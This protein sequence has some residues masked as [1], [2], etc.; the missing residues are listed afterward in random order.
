MSR[1]PVGAQRDPE[2]HAEGLEIGA[3][4]VKWVRRRIGGSLV[5]EVARHEGRP[6]DKIREM[7]SRHEDVEPSRVFVTGQAAKLLLDCPYLPE[8][9]CLETALAY[10]GLDPDILLSLGGETFSVYAVKEGRIH[11]VI[12]S[13]KCAAGTGEFIV[14]QLQRM[15][16]SL[17]DGIADARRSRLVQL[18]T[19]CS[20]HCKSDA[21]HK[22]NKGECRPGDVARS[23]IH[24]LAGKVSEL[25][26]LAQWPTRTIVLC[27][28]VS[29]NGLFVEDFC[30]HFADA[31]VRVVPESPYFEAFGACLAASGLPDAAIRAPRRRWFRAS[32]AS[33]ST[34]GSLKKAESL[35]DYRVQ[36]RAE[37]AIREGGSYLLGVDA[38]STTTKAILLDAADGRIGASAY[39]RTLGNPVRAVKA[40]LAQ[41]IRQVGNERIDIVQAGVTGSGRELVAV[42]LDDC[43]SFNEILAHAR[44]AI[45]EVPDVDTVFEIGGQDSKY[46]SFLE[47]VAVDYAMNEGCSA[48]T[49]SF[50][51]ESA[52]VDMGVGMEDISRIAEESRN[53]IRFGE[54]CAAF[55]NTDVRDALQQGA[56]R[57][58]VIGGLVYSIADN[59]IS[60]VVGPRQ[61]GENLLFLGGLALN[62]AVA[63]AMAARTQR[64][65]V[66]PPHPELMGCVGAALMVRDRLLTGELTEEHIELDALVEG[67]MESKETFRC[68]SCENLCEIQRIAVRGKVRPFGGLCSKYESL[69]HECG[70][71]VEGQD[72]V[73]VRNRMMFDEFGHQPA[74]DA[75]GTIGLPMA[76]TAFELFPFYAKLIEGLGYRVIL[77][78]RPELGDLK[79][80][81]AVCYPCKLMHA[82]VC[83]LLDRNVDFVLVPHVIEMAIPSGALHSYACPSTTVIPDILRAAFPNTDNRI[84]SP[85]VGLS[86]D[87]R[88]TTLKE[89]AKLGPRLGL[90]TEAARSAGERALSHYDRFCERRQEAAE[91]MFQNLKHEPTVILAGRPYTT[92]APVVNLS[93]PRKIMSRGYHVVPSDMLPRLDGACPP[94]DVWHF[95]QQITNA[96]AHIGANPN[97][98]LCMVSCFSCG[99]DSSIA[100]FLRQQ[101]AG[102]TFCYLEI[103]SHTAH[104]G[105]ET[106]LGAF[107]DIIEERRRRKPTAIKT[108]PAREGDQE[109]A[110]RTGVRQARLSENLD[111][112]LDSDG[113]RVEYDDPRV[114]DAWTTVHSPFALRMIT[115]MYERKGRRIRTVGR[116]RPQTMQA[117][118]RLCSGREC[119]PMTAMVGATLEDVSL[120]RGHDEITIYLGLDQEGPCQNG[121]WPLVWD[122]FGRRLQLRNVI[123]GVRPKAENHYL[124]LGNDYNLAISR[125]LILGD[126][127]EEAKNTVA[128]LAEDKAAALATFNAAFERFAQRFGDEGENAVEPALQEWAESVARIPLTATP[129]T[130]P[131]VLIIGGLNLLFVHHP[132]TEYF[133]EQKILPKLVPYSESLCWLASETVVRQGFRHGLITPKA[134]FSQTLPSASREEAIHVR[135]SKFGIN[136][137]ESLD[138]Q[139]RSVMERSGMMFDVPVPYLDVAEEGHRYAS[140][141]GFTET[142]VTTGRYVCS[143]KTGLYDGMVNLGSFNCQPAMNSQAIIRPLASVGNVPYVALDCEGPW[144]SAN[145]LRLLEAL[146]MQAKRVRQGKNAS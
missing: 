39:L 27:G 48:G 79:T 8:T 105:F 132:V 101:L 11:N 19:R 53:P 4:S 12:S 28:G 46:I 68:K 130:I 23:L 96:V 63:L 42:Y 52:A 26:G 38:G 97:L 95:T 17:A 119:V 16:L 71:G 103:D 81:A 78:D 135:Q 5:A 137:V 100:H 139:F 116:P 58:D 49:G 146:A 113:R 109:D 59:Y 44:S 121:A 93:L 115:G 134:Q 124:G 10:H 74:S 65:V 120:R 89:V 102:K 37:P 129:E 51:E 3:V 83:D 141:I 106:R 21:T 7:F 73:A 60:R 22:L 107:L 32:G 75:L 35:L 13:S 61:I 36:T 20:V 131:K 2:Q 111:C 62:R 85:H 9:E 138:R 29:T 98:S 64:K 24:D 122:T 91:E 123:F 47:G 140:H 30:E 142:T 86:E 117:A 143:A 80:A 57:E 25:V 15:G 133:I 82:A 33:F 99:P 43:R 118:R 112:I 69:R 34:H 87:L 76:L 90:T 14:Q 114:V 128:C 40:C 6:E 88:E 31:D 41:L 92:C 70:S 1:R 110:G 66:V 127:F 104:A 125:C 94:R 55:I 84:L 77:S 72:L 126:L 56:P 50:I 45:E 67:E 18:A 136:R 145:Q 108:E 54:R 144:L